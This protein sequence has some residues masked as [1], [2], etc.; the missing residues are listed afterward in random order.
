M[1][2]KTYVIFLFVIFTSL[3]IATNN[4]LA[5]VSTDISSNENFKKLYHWLFE[6][7]DPGVKTEGLVLYKDG[8]VLYEKYT[9]G[10]KD[11]RHLMW[12]MT[13]SVTSFLFGIAEGK[14]LISRK[15]LLYKYFKNEIDTMP[16][17]KAGLFKKITFEHVLSMSTGLDWKEYYENAPFKSSIARMLYFEVPKS[18]LNYVMKTDVV[19][20]PGS[21]FYYSSGDT[22]FLTAAL[23]R[24][25]MDKQKDSYPWDWFFD[26]MEMDAI[27][28]QD[29]E[30]VFVGASYMYLKS[31]DL[32]K[33]GLLVL[34]DGM[35]QG[36]Q[37][38][39]KEYMQYATSLSA[40]FKHKCQYSRNKS[41]G[42]QIWLNAPCPGHMNP[43]MPDAPGDL[44]MFL[45]HAGQSIFVFP[46][47]KIIAVRVAQDRMHALDRNK[48]AKLI[49]EIFK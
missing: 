34:N 29:G 20:N 25:I 4:A 19:H 49:Q 48:Y 44:V 23:A 32:I 21:K 1:I 16:Q 13:K 42:A 38:V 17:E 27:F 8:E 10:T 14:G 37:V 26:P 15:D 22:Q 45:G 47:Q 28:E 18:T 33:L 46:S 30:G 9:V 7:P 11:T 36:R 6:A 5:V 39:P 2:N 43:P 3:S 12:S 24:V 41:Y 35:Y 31:K 40:V